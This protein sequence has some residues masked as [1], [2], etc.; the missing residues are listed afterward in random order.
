MRVFGV[1]AFARGSTRKS[2]SKSRD[3]RPFINGDH[4][5]PI[6]VP[7]STANRS[8]NGAN[9]SFVIYDDEIGRQWALKNGCYSNSNPNSPKSS[10]I[11][12][13][14]FHRTRSNSAD[15]SSNGYYVNGINNKAR[16]RSSSVDMNGGGLVWAT[17]IP[18]I[19]QQFGNNNNNQKS[20]PIYSEPLPPLTSQHPMQMVRAAERTSVAR[21]SYDGGNS[22]A[23][24]S[25]QL[26]SHIYEYLVSRRS[27]AS[28]QSRSPGV[29]PP[30]RNNNNHNGYQNRNSNRFSYAGQQL[31]MRPPAPLSISNNRRG[32]LTSS[33]SPSSGSGS[34]NFSVGGSS[35]VN[36]AMG[37]NSRS[38]A[39]KNECIHY[40]HNK[41]DIKD[42]LKGLIED[43]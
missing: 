19:S 9:G 12:K 26:S 3:D 2:G 31:V 34:S 1:P 30:A 14:P 42:V 32:S 28:T 17:N 21:L 41:R 7:A 33:S 36:R 15:R 43:W 8:P 11:M 4:S 20:E 22:S 6:P 37:I 29:R 23:H 25:T 40:T 35:G 18:P 27:D 13:N 24:N 39:G 38:S 10:S 16:T 5:V